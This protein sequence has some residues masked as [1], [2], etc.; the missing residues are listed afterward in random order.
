M[1]TWRRAG[2]AVHGSD[3]GGGGADTEDDVRRRG[4]DVP[5]PREVPLLVRVKKS[6]NHYEEIAE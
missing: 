5:R 1:A 4:A 2:G 3:G 6:P